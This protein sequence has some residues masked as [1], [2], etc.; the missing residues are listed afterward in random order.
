MNNFQSELDNLITLMNNFNFSEI[1]KIKAILSQLKKQIQNQDRDNLAEKILLQFKKLLI[2]IMKQ[3][4]QK[5][6]E[7]QSK[8]IQEMVRLLFWCARK[9][10]IEIKDVLIYLEDFCDTLSVNDLRLFIDPIEE[11]ILS[12]KNL[13]DQEI[14]YPLKICNGVFKK[15]S[16]TQDIQLRGKVHIFLSKIL[17]LCHASGLKS[18]ICTE[19]STQIENEKEALL[20]MEN[21]MDIEEQKGNFPFLNYSFYSKFW[22]LQKYLQNPLNLSKSNNGEMEIEGINDEDVEEGEEKPDQEGIKTLESKKIKG[23]C[24]AICEVVEIFNQNPI[25][26]KGETSIKPYIKYLTAYS[27]MKIQ[28][29][30]QFF[31]KIWL[32][33]ALLFFYTLQNLNKEYDIKN[34]E[35]EKN[36]IKNAE[37]KVKKAFKLLHQNLKEDISYEQFDQFFMDEKNWVNI[38]KYIYLFISKI[39]I[40]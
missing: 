38:Y 37:D 18:K 7:E 23:L 6:S 36:T 34:I 12:I 24:A 1:G 35:N 40:D 11:G 32:I 16:K 22:S 29:N 4:T 13:S 19:I 33:Q 2:K 30:D 5:D 3:W 17:P 21:N 28:F 26:E 9:E 10:I 31:R 15:L 27:L 8:N 25:L 39:N 20:Q 14:N